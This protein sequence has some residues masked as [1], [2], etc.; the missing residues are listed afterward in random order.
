ME[1]WECQGRQ[2]HGWFGAGTCEGL[3]TA[4]VADC[5]SCAVKA[6]AYTVV[7]LLPR[8]ER[9]GYESWLYGGGMRQLEQAVPGWVADAQR[10][11][12]SFRVAQFGAHGSAVMSQT[13]QDFARFFTSGTTGASGRAAMAAA[14]VPLVRIASARR[15]IASPPARVPGAAVG[16]SQK[17]LDT[18]NA[19]LRNPR[20]NDYDA[21]IRHEIAEYDRRFGSTPG[22]VRLDFRIFKA[23]LLVETGPSNSAWSTQPLQIGN[24]GDPGLGVL[25]RRAEGSALVMSLELYNSIKAHSTQSNASFTNPRLNIQAGVAYA[26]T[27]MAQTSQVSTID[28]ADQSR[29]IYTVQT[30]DS[31][32]RISQHLGTTLENLRQNKIGRASCR[33]RVSLVV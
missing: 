18:V 27:R 4:P 25:L 30:G 33:E 11:E 10:D 31:L 23:M 14:L 7:G 15:E 22:Y 2:E 9:A 13:A 16:L 26:L 8:V 1:R 24:P 3:T 19:D 6:A 12:E 17:W 32:A 20:S 28:P 5:P 21:V 29:R